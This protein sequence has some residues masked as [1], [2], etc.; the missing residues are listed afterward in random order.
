MA[1]RTYPKDSWGKFKEAEMV[2]NYQES[3]EHINDLNDSYSEARLQSWQEEISQLQ[4]FWEDMAQDWEGTLNS[5][6]SM[7]GQK[8]AQI[9]DQAVDTTKTI[10]E[11]LHQ[12]VQ[13]LSENLDDLGAGLVNNLKQAWG[14]GLNAFGSNLG[15]MGDLGGGSLSGGVSPGLGW[16]HHGGVVKAHQGMVVPPSYLGGIT[17]HLEADEKLIVAQTG[18]GILPRDSMARLGQKHF[19]ALRTGQ[20]ERLAD[21]KVAAGHNYKIQIQVQAL[22]GDSVAGLNWDRIVSRQIIPALNRA[23]SRKV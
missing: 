23:Q 14:P 18:E 17:N 12:V 10:S 22:D 3:Q 9:A 8:F 7:A 11:S 1:K 20:F 4:G 19:E 2:S 15:L 13:D 21:S 6:E 5:M 16:F